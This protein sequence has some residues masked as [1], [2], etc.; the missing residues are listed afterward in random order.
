MVTTAQFVALKAQ[1]LAALHQE[2]AAAPKDGQ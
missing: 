2:P 1:L